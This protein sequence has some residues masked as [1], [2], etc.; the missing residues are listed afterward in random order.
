MAY[1]Y[2][3]PPLFP[4]RIDQPSKLLLQLLL[5]LEGRIH[6]ES[7]N[8]AK[9]GRGREG[10]ASVDFHTV[11]FLLKTIQMLTVRNMVPRAS[12]RYHHH[13]GGGSRT[14]TFIPKSD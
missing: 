10:R 11:L 6:N 9:K 13:G 1:P 14:S 4:G 12:G 3:L 2:Q 8:V 5:Q 7:A